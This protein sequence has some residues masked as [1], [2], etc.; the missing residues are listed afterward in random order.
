MADEEEMGDEEIMKKIQE[1][2]KTVETSEENTE[3]KIVEPV[4]ENKEKEYLERLQR[5]QAEFE[6]FRRR[7]EKEKQEK[8]MVSNSNLIFHLLTVLDNFEL[9]LKHN[10][11][12][13]VRL[14]YEQLSKILE[15]QG[16]KVIDTK[17]KF[18]PKIHEAIIKVDGEKDGV[19]LE[20]IEKGY[21]LND[22]LLRAS[23]VKISKVK[24]KNE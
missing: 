14:I 24:D 15:K 6:N 22:K 10:D 8:S 18:D 4:V 9:S 7:T 16:L 21:L 5:L 17:G 2:L 13:G 23:K 12:K 3:E 1:V 20:E 19:I 11:D